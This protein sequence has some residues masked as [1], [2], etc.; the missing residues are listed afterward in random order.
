MTIWSGRFV[1]VEQLLHGRDEIVG[2][3]AADAAIGEFDDVVLGAGLRAAAL[4]H[5]AVDAE[6]AEFVDDQRDPRAVRRSAA[7]CGSSSSCPRRES[8]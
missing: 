7:C 4:Q 1:A 2:D 3:G 5:V 6:I 8:R